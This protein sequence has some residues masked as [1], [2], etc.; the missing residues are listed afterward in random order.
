V[1]ARNEPASS[2]GVPPQQLEPLAVADEG[3]GSGKEGKIM[4][5]VHLKVERLRD[6]G[7]DVEVTPLCEICDVEG[8]PGVEA[9][10]VLPGLERDDIGVQVC[11]T[12]YQ[13]IIKSC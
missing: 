5:H 11:K 9:V 6:G 4:Y 13:A 1:V 8:R 2:A 7:V 3:R 12:C 10:K